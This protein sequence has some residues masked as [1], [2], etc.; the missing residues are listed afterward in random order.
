VASTVL[1]AVLL[2]RAPEPGTSPPAAV[3]QSGDAAIDPV[4][5]LADG[6]DLDLLQ[7]DLEF[8]EWLDTTGLAAPGSTG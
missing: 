1:V 6:D 8:Y 5:L 2:T 3:A 7:N 4:E